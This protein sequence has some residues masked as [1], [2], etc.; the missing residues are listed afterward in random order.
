MNRGQISN[1]LR[2]LGLS[3]ALDRL[4]Y[5]IQSVQNRK[6]NAAFKKEHPE[7]KLPPDYL[8]YESF[9]LDYRKYYVNGKAAAQGYVDLFDKHIALENK[10]ILDWGC[11]P[12]RLIRHMPELIGNG[13]SYYGTDYNENS[14]AWCTENLPNIEFNLNSLEAKLPYDS[15]FFDVIYGN[16]IFTHLSE[17]MHHDW[18]T[19]LHRVLKPGGIMVQTTQGTNFRSKM[20]PSELQKFEGGELVVRGRVKE[21]HRTFSAFHPKAFMETLFRNAEILEHIEKP[22]K[23]KWIP[24]DIWI[25]RK[26]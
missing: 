8:M 15:D 2:K 11:G 4:R 14:I 20:S 9:R 12:G 6:S 3:H 1:A 10:N 22:V 7:V 25:V 13:C 26:K 17:T 18:Y 16:S 21:G 24:Q 23:G 19:E 5:H